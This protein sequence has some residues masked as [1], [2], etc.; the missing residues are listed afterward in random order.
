MKI[1]I[2]KGKGIISLM[3]VILYPCLFMYFQNIGEGY[4]VEIFDA[5]YIYT[6][7]ST[8]FLLLSVII[9][10]EFWSS[11]FVAEIAML[12]LMNFNV[13][14]NVIKKI[15]PGMR[16][17]YLL[18][19]V[20]LVGI[21]LIVY[22]KKKMPNM[23]AFVNIIGITFGCLSILNFA[24]VLP[25]IITK[26]TTEQEYREENILAD[27][28]FEKTPNVYLLI[29][30]EYAGFE[31]LQYYYKYDNVE[32][33]EF[34]KKEQ[35]NISY[36]S[37]NGESLWTSTIL[38]NLL[39]LS[40]VASDDEYSVSN[41]KKTKNCTL[42]QM[43]KNNGY[44]INLI[45]H[46][47]QLETDGC[48]VLDTGE[49]SESLSTHIL[50]NGIWLEVQEFSQWLIV[51][52]NSQYAQML[53][54]ELEIVES[55]VDK[56]SK[57]QPTFTLSYICAPHHYF[58]VNEYGQG[59]S[60]EYELDYANKSIYLGQLKYVTKSIEKTI[61]NIKEKDPNALI[62]LQSDHGMRLPMWMV[63][64]H[65]VAM[66]DEEV[67]RPYMQNIINCVYYHGTEIN[68]EGMTGINTLRAVFNKVL[69]TEYEMLEPRYMN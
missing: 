40:Y 19:F 14:L 55:C 27:V 15:I 42:F 68:I 12:I 59:I 63:E 1:W 37:R 46:H 53:K 7:L 61:L 66:Y 44:M 2:D 38:P 34:L 69:G 65:G 17:A 21:L 5:V 32:F 23:I 35:F 52:S 33:E 39:N 10:R 54:R 22:L 30:D 3:A 26:I 29:Y 25:Q 31:N 20:I 50:D 28:E 6:L 57:R 43:F 24:V 48:N 8:C 47:G 62:I 13:I 49:K 36:S 56:V 4:F 9:L 16:K 51:K 45:N 18:A 60:S 58:A 41:F 67:E 64:Y 11:V